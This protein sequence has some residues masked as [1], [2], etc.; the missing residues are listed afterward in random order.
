MRRNSSSWRGGEQV[1]L[2]ALRLLDLE[3]RERPP[4]PGLGDQERAR[5]AAMPERRLPPAGH[6]ERAEQDARA[7]G[8]EPFVAALR[9]GRA[10][11]SSPARTATPAP[12]ARPSAPGGG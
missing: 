7:L 4:D 12:H 3:R 11:A 10:A 9:G 8:A 5:A 6:G 2:G 1:R